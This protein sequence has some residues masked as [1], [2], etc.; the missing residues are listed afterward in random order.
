[1]AMPDETDLSVPAND[2]RQ[3]QVFARRWFR[4]EQDGGRLTRNRACRSR[5]FQAAIVTPRNPENK[6]L[7]AALVQAHSLIRLNGL[8]VVS[9][10]IDHDVFLGCPSVLRHIR[11]EWDAYRLFRF[12]TSR[13]F[14]L[15][16]RLIHGGPADRIGVGDLNEEQAVEAWERLL[17]SRGF[18]STVVCELRESRGSR[19]LGFGC[20][21]LV[22]PEFI[23]NEERAFQ[24]GLNGRVLQSRQQPGTILLTDA[25]I[26]IANSG[27]GV[28]IVVLYSEI[29]QE[30][31]QIPT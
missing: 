29:S 26:G 18:Q 2:S 19:V 20:S 28:G 30:F 15:C 16:D 21:V 24:P 31:L 9:I 10:V 22:S 12:R 3:F 6:G 23:R 11:Y 27:E 5:V 17:S 7:A 25:E 4:K 14:N 8:L 13:G 1:M